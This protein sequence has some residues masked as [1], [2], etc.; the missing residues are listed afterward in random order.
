MDLVRPPGADPRTFRFKLFHLGGP[1]H[2]S[3]SLPMLENMGLRV[4]DEHPRELPGREGGPGVWLHDFGLRQRPGPPAAD[5]DAAG[6]AFK[7]CFARVWSGE[8][9][10]DGFNRLALVP[11][12]DWREI[13]MLRA[14][15]KY[16]RQVRFSLSQLYMED[17]LSAHPGLVLDLVGLFHARFDPGRAAPGAAPRLEEGAPPEGDPPYA[18]AERILVALEAVSSL[19]EDRILRTFFELIDGTL[20]TNYHQRAPDGGHRPCLALKLDPSCVHEMPDPKPRFEIFVYSPR[21][22]G[23]HLRGGPIARGGIRWSDRREDFRTEV[24]GLLKT[25]MVKNAVIVPVGSK[26]GF[27]LK[28]PPADRAALAEEGLACYREF[29]SALL[30]LTDN[31]VENGVENGVEDG[32]EDGAAAGAAAGA[33]D[34]AGAGIASPPDTVRHDGDD[35][36][37]VVAA[38]KGTA[39]FSDPANEL[40]AA[41]GFWLGDAFASGGSD[42]YDHKGIGIT[43]RG[44]W[45][46]VRSHFRVLGLD[47][48]AEPFTVAGIGDMSGD[49]FGNGM[50]LSRRI[51]LVAAFSHLHLFVDPSPDPEATFAERERLFR[52]PRSTWADYREDLVSAG[53]GVWPRS[54]KSI[55]LSAEAM[56]ALG[57]PGEAP[58]ART[59]NDVI[60]AILRAPVDLLWNGGIGTYVKAASEMHAAVGDRSNDPVRINAREL[61]CR[62]VGEGGNLGFTQAARVEYAQ[63]GGLVN[64]DAIDNSGGV[65]C[66][67]HEVNIKILLDAAVRNGELDAGERSSLLHSMTDEVAEQVLRNNYLQNAGLAVARTQAASLVEVHARFIERLE[68]TVG[69]DR[70]GE[71]LPDRD[72]MADRRRAGEGLVGPELAVLVAYAK[73]DLFDTLIGSALPEDPE[74]AAELAAYFPRVL[75]ERFAAGLP[76]HRLARE[77][78]S[79]LAAN[80]T[81]NRAG[82][83]FAFR[84]SDEIG[85]APQDAVRAWLALRNLYRLPELFDAIE[86]AELPAAAHVA[87]ALEIRKLVDRGARWLLRNAPRP[88]S[89]D[90]VVSRYRE[91]VRAAADR[92]PALASEP[93][94]AEAREAAER[95][96]EA[97]V[98]ETLAGRLALCSE[99]PSALDITEVAWLFL[100]SGGGPGAAAP[101]MTDAV[102]ELA[103]RAWYGVDAL[104]D[105]GW[106]QAGIAA[107]PRTDRWQALA[108]GALR[109][110]LL[111]RHRALATQVLRE[112]GGARPDAALRAWRNA[113]ARALQRWSEIADNLR[114]E[115]QVEYPMMAVALRE[116]REVG[117]G[118]G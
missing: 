36:Y 20:R 29:I 113:N 94:R 86:G 68:R 87:A 109:G 5:L 79:T 14:Y 55:S 4:E 108:R 92:I 27:V 49:V 91:G 75:R 76:R 2:L 107:L 64:T 66:S 53:G 72:E 98:P 88:L 48:A 104:L 10:D 54:A 41:A 58:A 19:D 81:V 42:G 62:V 18:I 103:A 105:I 65:D 73:L 24:L 47:P 111:R 23:V 83:T 6:A 3:D 44:A 1:V 95:L 16:L 71:G 69:L 77:I 90:A 34:G 106:L 80:E 99:L 74:M 25:Q 28:R 17:T 59:P 12:L 63:A 40:S 82:I 115:P 97:D 117:R 32:V 31:Y 52:L 60:R 57:I 8:A 67:D 84:L 114:A 13:A 35:P 102:V 85:A 37:L 50:L 110:D 43:A 45:E 26:G 11:G 101:A 39:T 93:I 89:V 78:I 30:E 22:E 96:V 33:R 21:L 70:A 38:D 51:R 7:G 118:G 15:A 116:L 46:S 9:E 100:G 112:G 56:A 61:R